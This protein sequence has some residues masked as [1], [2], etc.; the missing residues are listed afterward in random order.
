MLDPSPHES[1]DWQVLLAALAECTATSRGRQ[2]ALTLTPLECIDDVVATFDALEELGALRD[3]DVHLPIGGISDIAAPVHNASKGSTLD[4]DELCIAGATLDALRTISVKLEAHG[5][6]APVLA[7]LAARIEIDALLCDDLTLAF[8]ATGRLSESTYPQL[9]EL[10]A[11]IAAL[12]KDIR[13]TLDSLVGGDELGEVLQDNYWTLR[14]NRYVLPIKAHAKRWDIGIVHG[15]SGTGRTAFV[16]PHQVVMLN[17]RLRLAE[18]ALAA[19]EHRI[20]SQLSAA[21]GHCAPEILPAL[22]AAE[23]LD[24]HSA[25]ERF[26]EKLSATRPIVADDGAIK[27]VG[28]RHPVLA[29]RGVSVVPNDLLLSA[30]HPALVVSGPNAGGKTVALK[31]I[32]LCAL[33]VRHG[34]FIPADQRSRVDFFEHIASAIGDQ[35]T[36]EGDE[37]SFSAHL[38]LVDAMMREAHHGSLLLFDEIASG[39]DPAQG[40]ALAH[41]VLERM[42]EAGARVVVTTHFARLKGLASIDDRFAV[43]AMQY[44]DGAPTYRVLPGAVGESHAFGMARRIGME[45]SLL[46]RASDL[47]DAGERDISR[48]LEALEAERERAREAA[49]EAERLR[50]EIATE[51]AE[52]ATQRA[53]VAARSKELEHEGAEAFLQRLTKAE[54]A[55][56]KV[57]A[58]LQSGATHAK[59]EAARVAVDAM[60]GLVPVRAAPPVEAPATLAV[61]DRVRLRSMGTVGEVIA[62]GDGGVQVRAGGLTV[63]TKPEAL[64]R[65]GAALPP[66]RPITHKPGKKSKKNK[67]GRDRSE[68]A[69]PDLKQAVRFPGNTLDMRGMRVDEGYDEA[70]RFFDRAVLQGQDVVFLLHGHGTGALKQ[71][72]RGWLRQSAHVSQFAPARADQGGDAYTVVL[73]GG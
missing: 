20:L 5:D 21:L 50:A 48:A 8:D 40:A 33:L 68:V 22:D 58:D 47:M 3:L 13:A 65:L 55:I 30:D 63:N 2:C 60:R 41:A 27:L 4:A 54:E 16:E 14:E 37:S 71:G 67:K 64:E 26:A 18:G 34:C 52:L 31:T 17:N 53:R 1:L 29:L 46:A 57:V 24:L 36:I 10:R 56:G 70:D 44:L 25:R 72:L 73:L 19:E 6:D 7:A 9:A 66:R 43:A 61:G 39:T 62:I 15:T 45:E 69:P 38:R 59:A 32:G 28:A 51:A 42:L 12:H 11:S 23:E 35:Q 49:E